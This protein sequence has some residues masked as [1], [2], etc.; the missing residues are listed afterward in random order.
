VGPRLGDCMASRRVE[1]PSRRPPNCHWAVHRSSVNGGRCLMSRTLVVA[2]LALLAL[3]ANAADTWSTYSHPDPEFSVEYPSGWR[4]KLAD[5]IY[6]EKAEGISLRSVARVT[7]VTEATQGTVMAS[8]AALVADAEITAEQLHAVATKVA[9][10]DA[11]AKPEDL[12]VAGRRW[13]RVEWRAG[14]RANVRAYCLAGPRAFVVALSVPSDMLDGQRATHRHLMA[15]L[16]AAGLAEPGPDH[17]AGATAEADTVEGWIV[18]AGDKVYRMDPDGTT[19]VEHTAPGL[20]HFRVIPGTQVVVA[21]SA[22]GVEVFRNGEWSW[23]CRGRWEKIEYSMNY[24]TVNV[25]LNIDGRRQIDVQQLFPETKGVEAFALPDPPR[26]E[27]NYRLGYGRG[28]TFVQGENALAVQHDNAKTALP[29]SRGELAFRSCYYRYEGT[30]DPVEVWVTV[31]GNNLPVEFVATDDREPLAYAVV[32]D[33]PR[34][35]LLKLDMGALKAEVRNEGVVGE[36]PK[37][38]IAVPL[39]DAIT[40]RQLDAPID[41]VLPAPAPYLCYISSHQLHALDLRT[42]QDTVVRRGTE[43]LDVVQWPNKMAG[44]QH[45]GV[46]PGSPMTTLDAWQNVGLG[47]GIAVDGG[48]AWHVQS[49]SPLVVLAVLPAR[50]FNDLAFA[51]AGRTGVFTEAPSCR[52]LGSDVIG[53]AGYGPFRWPKSGKPAVVEAPP[54]PPEGGLERFPVHPVEGPR[55]EAIVFVGGKAYAVLSDG[56]LEER[57]AGI[58]F[59]GRPPLSQ[60]TGM[61]GTVMVSRVGPWDYQL[62]ADRRVLL[63]NAKSDRGGTIW[64][65][66]LGPCL[67]I[68][69]EGYYSH[70]DP[71]RLSTDGRRI[72]FVDSNGLVSYDT[73]TGKLTLSLPPPLVEGGDPTAGWSQGRYWWQQDQFGTPAFL[74]TSGYWLLADESRQTWIRLV[75]APPVTQAMPGAAALGGQGMR[76]PHGYRDGRQSLGPLAMWRGPSDRLIVLETDTRTGMG[77]GAPVRVY[78]L[79]ASRLD[80]WAATAQAVTPQFRIAAQW[81][82]D[83]GVDTTFTDY[84]RWGGTRGIASVLSLPEAQSGRAS[85]DAAGSRAVYSGVLPGPGMGPGTAFHVLVGEGGKVEG[86]PTQGYHFVDFATDGESLLAVVSRQLVDASAPANQQVLVKM[87]PS[88]YEVTWTSQP[89]VGCQGMV[90]YPAFDLKEFHE[91]VE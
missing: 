90:P 43:D 57:R 79:P 3:S 83:P 89:F 12:D 71:G 85:W 1:D 47:Y 49:V 31:A 80:D 2:L 25:L 36:A 42:G 4:A 40:L 38:T 18:G 11:K 6:Y 61:G 73:A 91:T 74:R 81:P 69:P 32:A 26:G 22:G 7:F 34:Q 14:N 29:S 64:P 75:H 51:N 30:P 63:V 53:L 16:R 68:T 58:F 19:T 20:R 33:G 15:T 55:P 37:P 46:P 72:W 88:T 9:E 76:Q 28:L 78:S 17:E 13:V 35:L 65:P 23:L 41:R 45:W 66:V 56:S 27:G 5:T 67:A 21:G 86:L 84:D 8:V 24:R 44:N 48:Y 82:L 54:E 39:T 52:P 10:A 50:Q 62:S 59:D 60:Q 87:D 70:P 77:M